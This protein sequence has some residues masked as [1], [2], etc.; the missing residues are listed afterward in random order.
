MARY[1][2]EGRDRKK[3]R[4]GIAVAN[5]R[6]E[7]VAKLRDEGIRVIE[8]R[9]MPATTLQKDITFGNPVKRDQFIMF[10]RQF[11]TLM[12]AGVTIVDSIHILS[13]QV[14]SKALI[15]ALSEI[16]EELRK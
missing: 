16:A 8:I 7:A 14:E 11:S 13:Q 1:K 2:Y 4:T 9:E 3:I 6:K 12:R 15:K 10:L 5:S